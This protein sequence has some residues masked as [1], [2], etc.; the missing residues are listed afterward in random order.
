MFFKFILNLTAI[1]YS[2]IKYWKD[3]NKDVA[4]TLIKHGGSYYKMLI[5][6]CNGTQYSAF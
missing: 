2:E 1:S 3:G 6:V 4:C 5:V